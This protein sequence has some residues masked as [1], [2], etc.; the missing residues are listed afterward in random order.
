[1][2][3]VSIS[4]RSRDSSTASS[5]P[6]FV[7]CATISTFSFLKDSGSSRKNSG[8]GTMSRGDGVAT[9][10][11]APA[12]TSASKAETCAGRKLLIA[13][14]AMAQ[15]AN[16]AVA[17]PHN[18]GECCECPDSQIPHANAVAAKAR[19]ARGWAFMDER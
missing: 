19:G 13:T 9:R 15:S 17:H 10:A 16:D 18:A 7:T 4:K 11:K 12:Q 3:S 1:M 14:E 8:E 5:A 2:D 6:S